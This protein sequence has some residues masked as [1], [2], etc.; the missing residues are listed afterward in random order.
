MPRR[1]KQ[2]HYKHEGELGFNPRKYIA[3]SG[4]RSGPSRYA[5]CIETE[6]RPASNRHKAQKAT[7]RKRRAISEVYQMEKA[8]NQVQI[9]QTHKANN[10]AS[11][12]NSVQRPSPVATQNNRNTIIGGI[13]NWIRK[14]LH[15]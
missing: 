14:I 1:N 13:K 6:S 12:E 10:Y 11:E 7:A 9:P 15:G 3:G 4:Y 8:A 2:R 5:V